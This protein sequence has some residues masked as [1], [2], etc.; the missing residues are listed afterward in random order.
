ME[1]L[2]NVYKNKTFDVEDIKD[3]KAKFDK[4]N[5]SKIS[6]QNCVFESSFDFKG[7][8]LVLLSFKNCKFEVGCFLLDSKIKKLEFC[9]N[10][11][12]EHLSLENVKVFNS[13][14]FTYSEIVLAE[15]KGVFKNMLVNDS[16]FGD[17]IIDCHRTEELNYI[18]N[19]KFNSGNHISKVKFESSDFC[20]SI[21]FN[22]GKYDWVVFKGKFNESIVFHG[23][24]FE[25]LIFDSSIF[26]NRISIFN[27]N[28]NYIHFHRNE[29]KRLILLSDDIKSIFDKDSKEDI[30]INSLSF[31]SNQAFENVDV[32]C[33]EIGSLDI[34][35]NDFKKILEVTCSENKT[36]N[37]KT[38]EERG[39]WINGVNQGSIIL[40]EVK[41]YV[42]L[43][44][45]LSG[46]LIVR[47]SIIQDIII[48][49][50]INNGSI[51][52]SGIQSL[53][54]LTI[55][56]SNVGRMEWY[57]T[58][59]ENLVEIVVA[60]SNIS[61]SIFSSYPKEISSYSKIPNRGFGIKDEKLRNSNLK[62]IYKQL[63]QIAK[64]VGD[65]N[66]YHYYKSK[67]YSYLNKQVGSNQDKILLFFN[68][69]SNNNGTSWLRGIIFTLVVTFIFYTGYINL[70]GL[71][72][73][74][75]FFENYIFYL[76]SFPK[77]ELDNITF[78]ETAGISLLIWISKI[79][80]GYGIY[81]TIAAFRKYG[82]M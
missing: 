52:F 63:K 45:I 68:Y 53:N 11:F 27:G 12:I 32:N 50:L 30:K 18:M 48:S 76:T 19:C 15:I 34:S 77:M 13:L 73:S 79:F 71:G 49:G 65:I 81:Q 61:N 14:M 47:N 33:S 82:K 39:I 7:L 57:N 44:G 1:E 59:L 23:G 41:A 5:S 72:K 17:L 8:D 6:F 51:I 43:D 10:T 54:L 40:N 25:T 20:S 62:N 28:Y 21:I 70:V 37:L 16:T 31:H 35:N 29:F 80:I 78:Q 64:R 26:D 75:Q 4:T 36:S 60:N 74:N 3:L 24:N 66:M 22:E 55:I 67:E 46:T 58:P 9:D 56:D 2:N 38:K 42:N 69:L